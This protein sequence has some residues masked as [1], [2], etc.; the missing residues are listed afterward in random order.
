MH[1]LRPFFMH[2]NLLFLHNN[3]INMK[4]ALYFLFVMQFG[5]LSAQSLEFDPASF[6]I[7]GDGSEDN[8]ESKFDITNIVADDLEFQWTL[9]GLAD[10]PREWEFIV[11]D[12]VNCFPS[13]VSSTYGTTS[14]SELLAGDSGSGS[15][16]K[17]TPHGV[18]ACGTVKLRFFSPADSTIHY[19]T[20]VFN[21]DLC[22]NSV[23][24]TEYE[25]LNIYPNPARNYFQLQNDKDVSSLAVYSILGNQLKEMDRNESNKY[26][27]DDL[28]QGIYLLQ[29]IGKEGE[30]LK[31]M[32]FNKQ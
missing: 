32:R 1:T 19:G 22:S 31:V 11:C 10:V 30:T 6:T 28:D 12:L 17:L 23:L 9:D 26:A 2:F 8:I 5:L 15:S 7:V 25:D 24:E 20:V 18:A 29:A 4:R 21:Y 13:S 27:I 16:V 3:K 14:K